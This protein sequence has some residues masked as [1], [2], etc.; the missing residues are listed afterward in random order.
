MAL[1]DSV[2]SRVQSR[3]AALPAALQ[4]KMAPPPE[5]GFTWWIPTNTRVQQYGL[6]VQLCIRIRLLMRPIPPYEMR[7]AFQDRPFESKFE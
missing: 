4:R 2:H 5:A 6:D 7:E 3:V 1:P